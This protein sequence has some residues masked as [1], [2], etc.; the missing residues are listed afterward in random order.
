MAIAETVEPITT[1]DGLAGLCE[2][3]RGAA[4]VTVDTEFKRETIIVGLARRVQK[5]PHQDA[6]ETTLDKPPVTLSRG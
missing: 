3:L 5:H 2:R 6:W 1:S 4:Y